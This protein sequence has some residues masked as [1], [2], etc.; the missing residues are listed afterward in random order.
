MVNTERDGTLKDDLKEWMGS[1]L[2][3]LLGAFTPFLLEL[4]WDAPLSIT[5]IGIIIGLYTVFA[6][7]ATKMA[8]KY[9]GVMDQQ[10]Y[11][12]AAE[13]QNYTMDAATK[14]ISANAS[15]SMKL[16]KQVKDMKNK[17]ESTDTTYDMVGRESTEAIEKA[18]ITP[19][20]KEIDETLDL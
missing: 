11:E 4:L 17:R 7:G 19:E 13:L 1:I 12:D 6:T 3:F 10:D 5:L 9:L 18:E 2:V 14:S 16:E 15:S 8:R 20:K